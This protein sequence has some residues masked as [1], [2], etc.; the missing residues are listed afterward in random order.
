MQF[1][2]R[3]NI[4]VKRTQMSSLKSDWTKE[5]DKIAMECSASKS[6][7]ELDFS[8][9]MDDLEYNKDFTNLKDELL[10]LYLEKV[11]YVYAL[12]FF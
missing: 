2:L 9:R 5:W 10:K 11:R 6:Q 8:H 3:A 12:A 7:Q 4:N 1:K